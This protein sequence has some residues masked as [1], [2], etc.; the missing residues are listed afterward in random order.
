[1]SYQHLRSY[2]DWY[3]LVLVTHRLPAQCVWTVELV[4]GCMFVCVCVCM[5]VCV[6]VGFGVFH[7]Y[8][9]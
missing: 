6:V 2:Q 4:A 3:Q 9:I 8:N 1:M 5:Y 7:P